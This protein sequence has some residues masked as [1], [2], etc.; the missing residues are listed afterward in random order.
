MIFP[1]IYFFGYLLEKFFLSRDFGRFGNTFVDIL[2]FVGVIVHEVSH[3][4]MCAL[5]GVPAY[6]TRVRYRSKYSPEPNPGGAVSI[7]YPLQM[8][9]LQG[10]LLCFA[11]LLFGTW[12]IYFLLQ[13]SFN[14]F[15]EPIIR[16]IAAFCCISIFLAISPSNADLSM[17][18]QSFQNDPTH[19]FYQIFLI[20]LSFLITWI[21][22][23]VHNLVFPF[24][25]LYY[26][27]IILSYIVLKYSLLFIKILI[28][29]VYSRKGRIPS[30]IPTKSL[31]RR[32]FK[33]DLANN[34]YK[35]E[36]EVV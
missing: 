23:V 3:R 28:K 10:F 5:T 22:I 15:F 9:L 33:P 35:D 19:S 11:P 18:K 26:F 13:V 1:F 25:F 17:L 6:N 31:V 8:T 2:F 29:K 21:I 34:Y 12:I 32:R 27:I 30:R 24:E 4:T 20:I 16:I 7:Q 14:T 36:L